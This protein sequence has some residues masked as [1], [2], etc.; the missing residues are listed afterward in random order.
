MTDKYKIEKALEIAFNHG[1]TDG[2]HHKAWVIDQ[3][4]QALTGDEYPEWVAE[5]EG[6]P[7]DGAHHYTWDKGIAP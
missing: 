7:E 6:D 4:V 5:Y 1:Q 3:M 2:A